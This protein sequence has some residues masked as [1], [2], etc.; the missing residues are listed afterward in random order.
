MFNSLR[1]LLSGPRVG[2]MERYERYHRVMS[3]Y[4]RIIPNSLRKSD[5]KMAARLLGMWERGEIVLGDENEYPAL[6]DF[7]IYGLLD[8]NGESAVMRY[9]RALPP[10]A[11]SLEDEV[12]TAMAGARYSLLQVTKK[13]RDAGLECYDVLRKRHL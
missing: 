12:L 13:V 8:K 7:A 3:A 1:A 2:M 11:D 10:P 6:M 4:Q 5:Y 9:R